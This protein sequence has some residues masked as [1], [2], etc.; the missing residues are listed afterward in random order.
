[1]ARRHSLEEIVS[2]SADLLVPAA[3]VF[4][5]IKTQPE[6]DRY[7]NDAEHSFLLATLACALGAEVE[8]SLELGL[9]SQ[10]ALVHDLVEVYAGDTTIWASAERHASKAER[11]AKALEVIERRFGG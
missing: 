3:T 10:Y 6:L 11:E 9:V 2:L 4:R 1:M 5:T 7:E 8:P